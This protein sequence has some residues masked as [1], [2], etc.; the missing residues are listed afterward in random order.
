MYH[1]FNIQHKKLCGR[2]KTVSVHRVLDWFLDYVIRFPTLT[3]LTEN[4]NCG[5]IWLV[6]RLYTSTIGIVLPRLIFFA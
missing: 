4:S 3:S 6:S 5:L 1:V 2:F